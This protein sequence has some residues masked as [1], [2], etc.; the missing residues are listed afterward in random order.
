MNELQRCFVIHG[1][2]VVR[3]L[4]V[5]AC[6]IVATGS[7][8]NAQ[9]TNSAASPTSPT[10]PGN[11]AA[12]SPPG[13]AFS[14]DFKNPTSYKDRFD[15][16]WSGE[17][18]AGSMWGGNRND[19]HADHGM[20]CENPNNS[21]RTIHLTSQE[22]ARDAAFYYCMPDGNQDKGHLMTSVNT[23]G[24]RHC[25]VFAKADFPECIQSLLGSKHHRSW[26]GEVDDYQFSHCQRICWKNRSRIHV[27]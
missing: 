13:I 7:S 16:G 11:P 20:M 18:D 23:L 10:S 27:T 2:L 3:M 24:I 25:L 5:S 1:V 12:S 17:W 4:I 26:W 21:H 9:A 14:E 19:W 15:Y 8:A 22:Q 6:V